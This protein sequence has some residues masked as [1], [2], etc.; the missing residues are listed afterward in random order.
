MIT[1]ANNPVRVGRFTSSEIYRLMS[2]GK[3][4]M[5][6]GELAARPK[7]GPG[8]KS[9]LVEDGPGEAFYNYVDEKRWERR[10]GRSIKE[11]V[12]AR[13][14]EWGNFIEHRAFR[15]L[16]FEYTLASQMTI[17]HSEIDCWCGTPDGYSPESVIEIKAPWTLKSF[18]T[19]YECQT[20]QELR[21]K[22]KQGE[23]YYWQ[24]VSNAILLD[25]KYAEL[26]V[27]LPYLSE[28]PEI[29]NE[30]EYFDGDQNKI[31]WIKFANHD[32][33]P[34]VVDGGEITNLH[35]IKFEVPNQ[36][37]LRLIHRVKLAARSL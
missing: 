37:K 15:Q 23:Q 33:L 1:V 18:C 34:Y 16:P 17:S 8:S 9:T 11:D 36:D 6:E 28:I 26:V 13:P 2:S 10:L 4:P 22:H 12:S 31:Q 14:L 20:I 32:D 3:R 29:Q 24:C 21:E 25:K 19:M 7:S 30:T 27:Y 5:T 35:V